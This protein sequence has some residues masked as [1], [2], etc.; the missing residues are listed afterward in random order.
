MSIVYRTLEKDDEE[1]VKQI[2]IKYL[3]PK[4]KPLDVL[5]GFLLYLKS[6]FL[7]QSSLCFSL[8]SAIQCL[9]FQQSLPK[10]ALISLLLLM[11]YYTIV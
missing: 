1:Q 11:L 10:S 7:I 3:S 9:L 5:Q 8:T 6:D 2:Y 4:L